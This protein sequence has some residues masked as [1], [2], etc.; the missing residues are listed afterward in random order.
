MG[1]EQEFITYPAENQTMQ[2]QSMLVYTDATQLQDY[3]DTQLS[4]ELSGYAQPILVKNL[5]GR[6]DAGAVNYGCKH[7]TK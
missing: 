2:W 7:R 1:A 4:G 3:F 5:K 6:N